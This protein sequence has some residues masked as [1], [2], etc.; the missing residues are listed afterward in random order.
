M[1]Q[2]NEFRLWIALAAILLALPGVAHADQQKGASPSP[3]EMAEMAK[4]TISVPYR[5]T[6]TLTEMNGGK[7]AGSQRYVIIVNASPKYFSP[8]YE[9]RPAHLK[10]GSRIP[11]STGGGPGSTG[12]QT[13]Y[14]DIGMKIDAT[15]RLVDKGLALSTHIDQSSIDPQKSS[16]L[17]PVI[18]QASFETTTLL[19]ANKPTV[20]GNVD[21]PGTTRTLQI[22]VEATK[23]Q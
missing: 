19:N 13:A 10:L 23:L 9:S 3:P 14:I 8:S 5:L 20:I 4:T 6:Y 15:L 21:L 17:G 16:T 22:Q 1:K 18:R 11:I 12:N 7:R 2:K